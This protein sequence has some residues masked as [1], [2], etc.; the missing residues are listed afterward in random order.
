MYNQNPTKNLSLSN[1]E[2]SS[3]LKEININIEQQFHEGST[4]SRAKL[5]SEFPNILKECIGSFS[6]PGYMGMMS[7]NSID[8]TTEEITEHL[9]DLLFPQK[10]LFKYAWNMNKDPQVD[11]RFPINGLPKHTQDIF[12][13]KMYDNLPEFFQGLS[14]PLQ[15]QIKCIEISK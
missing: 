11:F 2:I 8:G 6:T 5:K 10:G 13:R 14:F 12:D 9:D 15:E 3:R 1:K 7:K 4:Y